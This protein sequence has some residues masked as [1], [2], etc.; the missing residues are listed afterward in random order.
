MAWC[1]AGTKALEFKAYDEEDKTQLNN[2]NFLGTFSYWLGSG[3]IKKIISIQNL[4]I[5]SA[6]LCISPSELEIKTD[7][8]IQYEKEEYVK[9]NYYFF[10]AKLNNQTQDIGLYLLKKAQATAFIVQVR[11]KSQ[12]PVADTYIYIQRYY[13]GTNTYDVVSMGKTDESGNT[14]VYLETDTEDYRIQVVKNGEVVYTSPVQKVY[15]TTTPCTLPIS[16]EE[17]KVEGWKNFGDVANLI[18][19]GPY[20]DT[21]RNEIVYTYI[22]TSGTTSYGRLLVYRTLN[23]KKDVICN[24]NSTSS[25]ATL[26]CPMDGIEGTVYAEGYLSRSPEILVWARQF[27]INTIKQIFGNEGLFWGLIIIMVIVLAG[28]IVGGVGGGIVGMIGGLWGVQ[29]LGIASL[30]MITIW[31]VTA[32]GVFI[33]WNMRR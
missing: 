6:S 12:L 11:D 19:T 7:A 14:V 20:Y 5:N 1:S 3:E 27:V 29:I 21:D 33:L 8:I 25:A 15:C 16:I 10:E 4:S 32:I 26:S 22:D 2:W 13:P 24:I 17:G 28:S 9:R 18:Y 23:N 31:G 30:G